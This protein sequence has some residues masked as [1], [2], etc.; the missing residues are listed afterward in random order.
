MWD[1]LVRQ[2]QKLLALK[3]EGYGPHDYQVS[4]QGGHCLGFA[5]ALAILL[6]PYDPDVDEVRRETMRRVRG[7]A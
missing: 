3:E 6:N 5:K 2:T 1:E 4:A 7:A